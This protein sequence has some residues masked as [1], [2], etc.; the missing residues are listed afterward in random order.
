MKILIGV[1][2]IIV[3]VA[4]VGAQV[5]AMGT[6]FQVFRGVEPIW[7]VLAGCTLLI[8]YSTFGG[9]RALVV[10]DLVQFFLLPI[11][12][13]LVLVM[14][15]ITLGGGHST[16]KAMPP[17]HFGLFSNKTIIEFISLFFVLFLGEALV[18]PYLQRLMIGSP[19]KVAK[20][21]I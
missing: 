20:D 2:G 15:A 7:G 1:F 11:G 6:V 3:C 18:P 19:R 9:M 13:P 5:S 16:L 21:T 8:A 14:E 10:T 17:E 4:I 12:L